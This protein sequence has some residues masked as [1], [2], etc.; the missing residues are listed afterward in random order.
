LIPHRPSVTPDYHPWCL[1]P[2]SPHQKWR[3]E[4]LRGDLSGS[5]DPRLFSPV[6]SSTLSFLTPHKDPSLPL[7]VLRGSLSKINPKTR[8]YASP[9]SYMTVSPYS[10][11]SSLPLNHFAGETNQTPPFN[12][13]LPGPDRAAY[14]VRHPLACI[15]RS[16]CDLPPKVLLQ[17]SPIP[18]NGPPPNF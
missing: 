18:G 4:G 3:T 6:Y 5:R 9:N 13:S 16:W 2:L 1:I 12:K 14:V 7:E 11:W 15:F 10:V 8:C 17:E